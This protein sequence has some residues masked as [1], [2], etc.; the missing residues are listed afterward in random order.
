VR[1]FLLIAEHN[2]LA[3]LIF[4]FKKIPKNRAPEI[5]NQQNVVHIFPLPLI[6]PWHG[7][8]E[9]NVSHIYVLCCSCVELQVVHQ[10][11]HT[12]GFGKGL[13][14]DGR[15]ANRSTARL[16]KSTS[17]P[18]LTSTRND[19]RSDVLLCAN[20]F[21]FFIVNKSVQD[22]YRQREPQLSSGPVSRLTMRVPTTWWGAGAIFKDQK[23]GIQSK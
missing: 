5:M 17:A 7:C 15:D 1:Y 6:S 13:R 14:G 16:K 3:E 2:K 20:S 9:Y 23:K 18:G 11:I 10:R 19:R 21:G 4:P 12:S 22:K 8:E